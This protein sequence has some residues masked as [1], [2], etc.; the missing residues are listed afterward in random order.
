MR[1]TRLLRT[2]QH[3]LI[4]PRAPGGGG[5]GGVDFVKITT[6]GTRGKVNFAK[7]GLQYDFSEG[8][9]AYEEGFYLLLKPRQK[10]VIDE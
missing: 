5:G 6:E 7:N 1:L 10:V 8:R 3:I 4:S 2:A 9:G